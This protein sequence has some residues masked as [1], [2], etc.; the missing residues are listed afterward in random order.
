MNPTTKTEALAFFAT[1]FGGE[2]H[3]P[4]SSDGAKNLKPF[5]DGWSVLALGDLSS[6]DYNLLTT[7]VFLAHDRC[8]RVSVVSHNRREVRISIWK[9]ERDGNFSARHPTLQQAIDGWRTS[10]PLPAETSKPAEEQ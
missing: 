5:G 2:H 1:I 8:F 7:L 4:G 6:F 3:I 9:R 10:H